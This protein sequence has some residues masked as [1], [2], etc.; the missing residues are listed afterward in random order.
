MKIFKKVVSGVGLSVL[1]LTLTAS[2]ALAQSNVDLQQVTTQ[3][4]HTVVDSD[5]KVY[6]YVD[7][8]EAD[9]HIQ[10]I[11]ATHKDELKPLEGNYHATI[12]EHAYYQGSYIDIGSRGGNT[13]VYSFSDTW[14]DKISSLKAPYL[15]NGL[16]VFEHANFYGASL[17]IAPGGAAD[18]LANYPLR[19]G[20]SWNDQIS[21][22]KIYH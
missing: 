22:M 8:L 1:A 16:Q 13:N 6:R 15:G 4:Q 12:W 18:Y 21:S 5:G 20:V 7:K 3:A 19:A 10:A 9:R 14:N 2:V 17:Y 11:I